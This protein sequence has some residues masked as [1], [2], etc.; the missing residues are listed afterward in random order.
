M[1]WILLILLIL[2]FISM[3]ILIFRSEKR[4][5]IYENTDKEK[6]ILEINKVKKRFLIIVAISVILTILILIIDKIEL[7]L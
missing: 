5:R 2:S 3:Y 6:M 1:A 7:L 4:I